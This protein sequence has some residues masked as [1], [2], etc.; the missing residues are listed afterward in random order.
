[1]CAGHRLCAELF[2]E[3]IELD[4]WGYP[5]IEAGGAVPA[6]LDRHARRA[7]AAC[8]DPCAPSRRAKREVAI[9]RRRFGE[10][11]L[12]VRRGVLGLLPGLAE[13]IDGHVRATFRELG[14][15]LR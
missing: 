9:V 15:A 12:G 10:D 8:P 11:P 1:M 5:V 2:P 4:E 14:L 6:D 7:V 3:R 13:V